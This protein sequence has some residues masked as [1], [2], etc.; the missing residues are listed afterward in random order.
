VKRKA[1][2]AAMHELI[3]GGRGRLLLH[4]SKRAAKKS[5]RKGRRWKLDLRLVVTGPQGRRSFSKTVT[6]SR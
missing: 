6:V 3:G 1:L 5:L 4:V 2:G